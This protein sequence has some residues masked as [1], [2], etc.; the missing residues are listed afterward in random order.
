MYS[1]FTNNFLKK[2]MKTRLIKDIRSM[3]DENNEQKEKIKEVK[4]V[5]V[6]MEAAHGN[7]TIVFKEIR[8][9]IRRS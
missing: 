3:T 1:S 4:Q 8:Q 9:E 5:I 6:D 2:T 7:F